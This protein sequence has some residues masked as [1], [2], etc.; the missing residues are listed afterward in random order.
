MTTGQAMLAYDHAN[1]PAG[2]RGGHY[3]YGGNF[4]FDALNQ[5]LYDHTQQEA[6][7]QQVAWLA[8]SAGGGSA[9][10]MQR[11]EELTAALVL[12]GRVGRT[13]VPGDI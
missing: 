8:S 11:A 5:W 1:W 13:R 12:G 9:I 4:T 6:C 3:H 10:E 2:E 7:F